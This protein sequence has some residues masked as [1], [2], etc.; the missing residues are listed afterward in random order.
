M[1]LSTKPWLDGIEA[2]LRA[3]QSNQGLVLT[4]TFN[5]VKL[6]EMFSELTSGELHAEL[7]HKFVNSMFAKQVKQQYQMRL[8]HSVEYLPER[9][10][11]GESGEH[12]KQYMPIISEGGPF[13]PRSD[14]NYSR[15][16]MRGGKREASRDHYATMRK[17]WSELWESL[18]KVTSPRRSGSE[19]SVGMGPYQEVMRHRL[20]RYMPVSGSTSARG[21]PNTLFKAVEFGTGIAENVGG[22][23]W[24]RHEGETK[25]D[26]GSWWLGPSVGMGAHFMGQKGFHFLYD[27]RTRRPKEFYYKYI[28]EKFPEFVDDYLKNHDK[29]GGRVTRK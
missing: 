7:L 1:K 20:S 21:E 28:Y 16:R 26:D 24:V 4:L 23:Q 22:P 13:G 3:T 27:E 2:A 6:E 12:Y 17:G 11:Y 5:D 29:Y 14:D 18:S 8:S 15:F 10:F 9:T 19:I 25:E